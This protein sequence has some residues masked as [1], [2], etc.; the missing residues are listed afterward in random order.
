M[1]LVSPIFASQQLNPDILNV[2]NDIGQS[3]Q[4]DFSKKEEVKI[5][6]KTITIDLKTETLSLNNDAQITSIQGKIQA[7][8]GKVF[9][10]TGTMVLSGDVQ[11]KKDE[12]F[13]KSDFAQL[14]AKEN[15]FTAKKNVQFNYSTYF[16]SSNEAKFVHNTMNVEFYDDVIFK[17]KTDYLKGDI[18]LFNIKN[19]TIHTKGKSK[20]KITNKK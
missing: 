18:I 15:I 9:L 17:D 5:S 12:Y 13:L 19:E 14:D 2:C 3:C 8:Q 7:N 11:L 1:V 20:A 6:A 4:Y 10:E 16:A